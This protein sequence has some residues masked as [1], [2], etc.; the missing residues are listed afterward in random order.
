MPQRRTLVAQTVPLAG[1]GLFS[2]EHTSAIVA[3]ASSGGIRFQRR[4]LPGRPTVEA[5]IEN[6]AR[7]PAQAGLPEG[8]PARSTI[9]VSQEDPAC[10][11]M[12]VEHVMSALTALGVTDAIIA[13]D[14]P[15][16]PIL[17][18]GASDFVTFMLG[19]GLGNIGWV[20]PIVVTREI[21]VE[22]GTGG[23]I[24]ASP[25]DE[26]VSEFNYF[27]DYGTT[28][29]IHAQSASWSGDTGVY[30]GQVAPA[31]TFCLKA[32]AEAMKRMGLFKDFEP[33]DLLVID[34][35]G[36]PIDNAMRYHDEPARHKLLDLIGDLG[37]AGAPLLARITAERSGHALN[38]A[39]VRAVLDGAR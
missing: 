3:P 9:L 7:T 28:S 35:D 14:G 30:V 11:V 33:S 6:V 36:T 19:V 24:T 38:H 32:E 27:L 25:T 22:D 16:I 15:E 5:R 29:P 34:D 21:V 10:T 4:D 37:L 8:F 31:R 2:G 18:G 20:E 1:R 39:L 13:V 12:T 26:Q 23:R 17:D